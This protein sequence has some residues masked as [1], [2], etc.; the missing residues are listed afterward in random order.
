MAE[1]EELRAKVIASMNPSGN[2]KSKPK[3]KPTDLGKEGEVPS[4]E[5]PPPRT[6]SI[7]R[8]LDDS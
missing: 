8:I 5:V 6:I 2:S 7:W 1:I 4:D 3:G